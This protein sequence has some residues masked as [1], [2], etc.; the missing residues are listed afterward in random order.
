M[1]TFVNTVSFKL[2]F[3]YTNDMQKSRSG[4]TIVELLIVIVVIAILAAISVVAFTGI[5]SR[6]KAAAISQELKQLDKSFNLWGM[7]QGFSRW[8][9]ETI[10][11]GG[12]NISDLIAST[13]P[14]FDSLHNYVQKNPSVSG[15]GTDAWFY[16]QDDYNSPDALAGYQFCVSNPAMNHC[17]GDNKTDCSANEGAKLTGVNIVISWLNQSDE[18]VAKMVN[19]TIDGAESDAD[20]GRCGKLRWYHNGSGRYA[21]L[22]SISYTKTVSF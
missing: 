6:A 7:E 11:G 13:T 19:K 22:Y 4:F 17:N 16:D 12:V 8:P 1:F 3:G 10:G 15:I 2:P 18:A 9:S 5:Q 20:W 21:I 14:P